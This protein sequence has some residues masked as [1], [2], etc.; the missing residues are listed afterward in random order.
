MSPVGLVLRALAAGVNYAAVGWLTVGWGYPTTPPG[1]APAPAPA[2]VAVAVTVDPAP[3]SYAPDAVDVTNTGGQTARRV[4]AVA[5]FD[6]RWALL[7]LGGDW[8]EVPTSDAAGGVA[9]TVVTWPAGNLDPGDTRTSTLTAVPAVGG[10]SGP[11]TVTSEH[12]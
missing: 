7:V 12:R 1:P 10:D 6:G 11:V 9:D 4:L 8:A 5:R 2:A 3:A